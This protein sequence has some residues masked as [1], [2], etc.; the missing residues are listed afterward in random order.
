MRT[1]VQ[2]Q[3]RVIRQAAFVRW[4]AF[5]VVL[6]LLS[7]FAHVAVAWLDDDHLGV[8]GLLAD[9]ELLV[10]A[11]VVAA[12]GLGDLVF[13][14]RA[15]TTGT[16]VHRL[17]AGAVC[18]GA[19]ITIVLS[20]L[21]FGLITF[22]TRSR[23]AELGIAQRESIERKAQ[24]DGL[25]SLARLSEDDIQVF[26]KRLA[27][28]TR[29]LADATRRLRAATAGEDPSRRVGSDA[30]AA[31][32]AA[33]VDR[34]S[35]ERDQLESSGPQL[36][37]SA[38][39]LRNTAETTVKSSTASLQRSRE[40]AA[41]ASVALFVLALVFGAASMLLMAGAEHARRVASPAAGGEA[42]HTVAPTVAPGLGSPAADPV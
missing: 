12:A 32:L 25:V 11:T 7:V 27:A 35:R 21:C 29:H 18:T 38:D 1:S 22:E 14:L 8:V 26:E 2:Q 10:L 3:G 23:T 17:R 36:R 42:A 34:F 30:V 4:A 40:R 37:A 15:G 13:D 39:T 5:G 9:G 31:A 19:L 6:P 24:A 20:V 28:T 33:E 41:I 16:E